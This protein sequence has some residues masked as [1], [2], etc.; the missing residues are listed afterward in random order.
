M[1]KTVYTINQQTNVDI[2]SEK[3]KNHFEVHAL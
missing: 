2:F 3:K 1:V